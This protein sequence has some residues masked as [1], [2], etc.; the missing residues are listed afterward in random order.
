MDQSKSPSY[1]YPVITYLHRLLFSKNESERNIAKRLALRN[2]EK[3]LQSNQEMVSFAEMKVSLTA[4]L[5]HCFNVSTLPRCFL[6]IK[7]VP[8]NSLG[9]S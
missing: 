2:R 8:P 9:N 3:A 4:K 6:R 7:I 1:T 5:F